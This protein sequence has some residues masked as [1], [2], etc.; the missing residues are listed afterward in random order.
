MAADNGRAVLREGDSFATTLSRSFVVPANPTP[1][2]FTYE[3]LGLDTTAAGFVNDAFEAAL[4]DAAGNPLAA[5]FTQ[6]RDAF[7]NVADGSPAAR[8][9]GTTLAGQTITADLSGIPAGTVA[10]LVLRL[11]NND[12]DTGSSVTLAS[13]ILPDA[14]AAPQGTKFYVADPAAGQT[15]RYGPAG[16][17][18]GAFAAAGNPLGIASNPAGDTLWTVDG[19]TGVVTVVGSNG[20]PV[21]NWTAT[22]VAGAVGVTVDAG[23]LWLVDRPAGRVRRYDGGALRTS[24]DAAESGGFALH[25]DN[26]APGDLVT[27]GGAVWVTDEARAEVFVY[28]LAGAL[29]G[30]WT[31][32]GDNAAPSGI[33]LDPS[34]G[35]DL[36]VVDRAKAAVF[37]YRGGRE[38]RAGPHG[39]AGT[40]ALAAGNAAPEAI[41][42]PPVA[43]AGYRVTLAVSVHAPT[44]LAYTAGDTGFPAG[45]YV[46]SETGRAE[47]GG[48][49]FIYRVA[50]DGAA[51]LFATLLPEADPD[52]LEFAPPGSAYGPYLYV[53][54]N[55]RDG[56]RPGDQGGTIQRVTSS[57]VVTDFSPV[58]LPDGAAPVALVVTAGG[59]FGEGIYV[60]NATRPPADIV[61]VDLDGTVRPF[62][63]DGLFTPFGLE[64]V[65]VA[66]GRGGRFGT[67]LYFSDMA[68]GINAIRRVSP[69]GV[70][71]GEVARFDGQSTVVAFGT[72]GVFG[73]DL[74]V[75]VS[76][77]NAIYRI[78]PDGS[79]RVIASGFTLRGSDLE[80][81]PDG[82]ALYV[83]DFG[84]NAVYAITPAAG[85][86]QIE[87]TSP[88]NGGS[89]AAGST[90][91][92]SGRAFADAPAKLSLV[93]IDGRPVD[94]LDAAGNFFARVT[95]RPGQNIYTFTT[96]AD[97]GAG[98]SQSATVTFDDAGFT[99]PTGSFS[100]DVYRDRGV[101]FRSNT[102]P[103]LS[104]S[105][106]LFAGSL[107]ASRP[108]AAIVGPPGSPGTF[109]LNA[110]RADF[111]VPGTTTPTTV[112]S[113]SVFVGDR[114]GEN[115]NVVL[116]A[117]A[118]DGR[119]IAEDF[120]ST[121]PQPADPANPGLSLPSS[122]VMSVSGSGIAYVILSADQVV[123]FDD[124]TFGPVP[125]SASTTLTLTGT[126]PADVR[127]ADFSRF[128]DLSASFR[129]EYARTS[130]H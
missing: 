108:Y 2:T 21:G 75:A 8:G 62:L 50:P 86:P 115:D 51:E 43:E 68:A 47:Q 13:C 92:V 122:K 79:K 9:A 12:A 73:N 110:V 82:R 11:V 117:Y 35:T 41:A 23:T 48:D 54:A 7:F 55:N 100:G 44:G 25:P 28:D 1:L 88:P 76:G 15:Y 105:R 106:D 111:V 34:G 124:F 116:R 36:W 42:D 3:Q 112:S 123:N 87:L 71:T 118:A 22:D 102:E 26:A 14:A 53:A 59:G 83:S 113:V 94:A 67:D 72:G 119:V 65:S 37:H 103:Q 19:T 33:T 49:D 109:D 84:A 121:G 85:P 120:F 69:A 39:A 17:T 78:S 127:T 40:F 128:V 95:V 91:L 96:T 107:A 24:G 64:L 66:Q 30:R 52:A 61:R 70:V 74:Y 97:S 129:P 126:A 101:V 57:G 90:V 89:V 20:T 27:D 77:E 99:G 58:G 45:L 10:T 93:T 114:S 63:D 18:G 6:G 46:G 31:L 125:L 32:D 80:F 98:A 130:F 60:A 29:L 38:W 16:L 81:A 104:Y 4:L 5:T 56:G